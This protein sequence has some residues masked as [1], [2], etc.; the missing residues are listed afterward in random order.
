MGIK[1]NFKMPGSV[2]RLR[3]RHSKVALS[4]NTFS[5]VSRN[6]FSPFLALPWDIKRMIYDYF[7]PFAQSIPLSIGPLTDA[8]SSTNANS[9]SYKICADG[10]A[11]MLVC[12][13][14]NEEASSIVYGC[15]RFFLVP[16]E[17]A[18]PEWATQGEDPTQWLQ[19]IRP[20]T[21][22]FIQKLTIHVA[23]PLDRDE[24]V[25]LMYNLP[26]VPELEISVESMAQWRQ[27]AR[28]DQ[29]KTLIWVFKAI[30]KSRAN[31]HT[32][33]NDRGDQH[34]RQIFRVVGIE[35]GESGTL[36]RMST[37][38]QPWRPSGVEVI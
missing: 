37:G 19:Y 38:L 1:T 24:A 11:L 36:P 12:R 27:K 7:F 31:L 8:L 15:N 5:K 23:L 33:W 16:C 6:T 13:Q 26:Y 3:P 35:A 18:N 21:Q 32:V 9:E 10:M 22:A 28:S 34:L 17:S 25:W 4:H 29:S 14:I 20:S 30:S 2:R